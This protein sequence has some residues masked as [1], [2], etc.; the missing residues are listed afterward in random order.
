MSDVSV[1]PGALRLMPV[2]SADVIRRRLEADGEIPL[3][4]FTAMELA[5]VGAGSPLRGLVASPRFLALDDATVL[6]GMRGGLQRLAG[7]RLVE[8][9]GAR[10]AEMGLSGIRIGGDLS[11]IVAIRR[12]PALLAPVTLVEPTGGIGNGEARPSQTLLAV[13]HGLAMDG[14][15]LVGLLE[16]VISIDSMH[17]FFMCSPDREPA[18]LLQACRALRST[19][20]VSVKGP[21]AISIDVYVPDPI[22]PRHTKLIL[23][24]EA[25]SV[26]ED[27][28]IRRG[29]Q[30]E[31]WDEVKG[32]SS[33]DSDFSKAFL[34][35]VGDS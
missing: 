1:D 16:E 23:S 2:P 4:T 28:V 21:L 24:Y 17:S 27:L 18:R 19:Q 10:Q 8:F 7:D 13:L 33:L 15:G 12:Q 31:E 29:A 22:A 11:N 5:A 34:D 9:D 3:P 30:G 14:Y 32:G 6:T 26:Y 35:A 25:G 20:E